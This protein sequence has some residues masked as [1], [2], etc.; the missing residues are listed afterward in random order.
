M[1]INNA[2]LNLLIAQNLVLSLI[3]LHEVCT[4]PYL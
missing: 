3:E 4:C 2:S 1:L